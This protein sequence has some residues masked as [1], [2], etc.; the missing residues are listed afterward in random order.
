MANAMEDQVVGLVETDREDE[1]I[2]LCLSDSL[3]SLDK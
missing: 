1:S 3:P 2:P